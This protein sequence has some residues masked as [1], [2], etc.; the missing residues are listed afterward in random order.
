MYLTYITGSSLHEILNVKV[1][2]EKNHVKH[3]PMP[4]LCV[5]GER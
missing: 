5:K 1:M 2:F 4:K 3:K